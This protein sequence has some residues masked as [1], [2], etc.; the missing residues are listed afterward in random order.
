MVQLSER[1]LGR[2]G[3]VKETL[4]VCC[5][6]NTKTFFSLKSS[7]EEQ[8]GDTIDLVTPRKVATCYDDRSL[9]DSISD[10]TI[11]SFFRMQIFVKTLTGRRIT[12]EVDPDDRIEDVK[13]KIEER[14]GIPPEVQILIFADS[15]RRNDG[16]TLQNYSIE[17][18]STLH[19]TVPGCRRPPQR[20]SSLRQ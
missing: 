9:F 15:H 17:K 11:R 14:E 3:E 19:L 10:R 18:D 6:V 12:L 2:N 5:N 20:E 7:L 8:K 16:K 13:A 1:K 4:L